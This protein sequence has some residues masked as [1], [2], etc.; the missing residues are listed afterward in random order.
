MAVPVVV[1]TPSGV[2]LSV[3]SPVAALRAD[4]SEAM[5]YG[6]VVETCDDLS[7]SVYMY[8]LLEALVRIIISVL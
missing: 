2:L 3:L 7:D 5:L 6:K 1:Q 8:I 4:D